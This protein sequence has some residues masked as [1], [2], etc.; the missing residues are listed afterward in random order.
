MPNT[1]ENKTARANLNSLINSLSVSNTQARSTIINT[2]SKFDTVSSEI[3]VV[4][5]NPFGEDYG[6]FIVDVDAVVATYANNNRDDNPADPLKIL[7]G[8]SLYDYYNQ[9]DENGNVIE[10]SGKAYV[11]GIILDIRKKYS[12]RDAAV[13]SAL[14]ILQLAADKGIKID[15]E[16]KGTAGIRPYVRTSDVASGVDCNPFVS[17]CVDKG[18]ETG[19]QWRPVGSFRKIGTESK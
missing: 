12:G 14:A 19:F 7:N 16:H 18:V 17:W 3:E 13:N 6:Q 11:E 10:G 15:Y 1:E 8:G 9:Y 4:T 2:I 5:Y